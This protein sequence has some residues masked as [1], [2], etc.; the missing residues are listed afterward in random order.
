MPDSILVHKRRSERRASQ[1]TD[2]DMLP[3]TSRPASAGV[4]SQDAAIQ[5][6]AVAQRSPC[7]DGTSPEA[8]DQERKKHVKFCEDEN[9]CQVHHLPYEDYVDRRQRRSLFYSVG[10]IMRFQRDADRPF[11]CLL[12]AAAVFGASILGCICRCRG[13]RG[14]RGDAFADGG[15]DSSGGIT[16]RGSAHLRD[17]TGASGS[18][19]AALARE[20]APSFGGSQRSLD[21]GPDGNLD[22]RST[23]MSDDRV[24]ST[25]ASNES[26]RRSI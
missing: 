8:A 7:S 24:S 13:A 2:T 26:K 3:V 17:A 6:V 10:D 14:G 20:A 19:E 9:L 16:L 12:Q 15:A 22:G 11:D 25:I 5:A 4:V 23:A 1:Q 18:R 21:L